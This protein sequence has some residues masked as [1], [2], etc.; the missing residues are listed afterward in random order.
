MLVELELVPKDWTYYSLSALTGDN[1]KT[2]EI[3]ISE[4]KPT[5]I[6]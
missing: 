6:L 2:L 3:I 4:T 1:R 5:E